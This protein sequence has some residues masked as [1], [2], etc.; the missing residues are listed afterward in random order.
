MG[1]D[2]L[3]IYKEKIDSLNIFKLQGHINSFT[4]EKLLNEVSEAIRTGPI[5]MDLEEISTL[6]SSGLKTLREISEIVYTEKARL[7][8]LNLSSTVKQTL[9]MA[10]MK[11]IFP[12]A[13]NEELAMKLVNIRVR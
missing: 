1:F 9:Q 4:G 6:S 12:I 2:D 11:S 7:I 8:L 10:N 3:S 13:D 5:I